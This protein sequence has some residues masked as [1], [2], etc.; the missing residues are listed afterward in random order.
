MSHRGRKKK[1]FTA[2][3]RRLILSVSSE[4]EARE[5]AQKLGIGWRTVYWYRKIYSSSEGDIEKKIENLIKSKKNVSLIELS[6]TFDIGVQHVKEIIEN[7]QDKGLL[8][9]TRDEEVHLNNTMQAG[10]YNTISIEPFYNRWIKFGVVSDTHLNSKYER[11]DILNSLYDIFQKE[12]IVNV[13]HAGNIID[14]FA[15]FNQFD[16]YNTGINE[17]ID[18]LLKNY[19]QREGIV[20]HFITGDDHEGWYVQREHV[21]IGKLIEDEAKTRGRYDMHHLGYIEA[22]VEVPIGKRPTMI[23]IMHPGGGTAYAMSYKP[24]K[25]IEAL[26]GGEKPDFLII[27]HYH[28]AEEG[29]IRNVPYIQAGCTEDQTPFM[30]KKS[31]KAHLGGWIVELQIA[32]E[33]YVNRIRTEF[34]RYFDREFC[35]HGEQFV[36]RAPQWEYKW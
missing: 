18:Y 27:G 14:G 24:Q 3:E 4:K 20:T 34:I 2:A 22:N 16:V 1:Q 25:I 33:G 12:G 31:L 23:R 13:F 6:N 29:I 7:L 26:Q 30:R 15:K 32:P 19:P 35:T 36:Q 8:V 17:Q 10:T 9:E 28:K 11:L 5:V 21:N